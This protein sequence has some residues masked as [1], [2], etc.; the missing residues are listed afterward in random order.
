MI[1]GIEADVG[2]STGLCPAS[3]Y[4]SAG[5]DSNR[6]VQRGQCTDNILVGPQAS[7]NVRQC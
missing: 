2:C 3:G 6:E 5:I 4:I 1:W 7:Q